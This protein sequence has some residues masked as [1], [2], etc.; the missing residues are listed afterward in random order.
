[1]SCRIQYTIRTTKLW[2]GLF[3][4]AIILFFHG[5]SDNLDSSGEGVRGYS[6]D[7]KTLF[8]SK[9]EPF[10]IAWVH[11]PKDLHPFSGLRGIEAVLLYSHFGWWDI[12]YETPFDDNNILVRSKEKFEND[13]LE[14]YQ[15][16]G[17]GK[18]FT[19]WIRQ[20]IRFHNGDEM[21][22]D[23][24][25]YSIK[26]MYLSRTASLFFGKRVP[27]L[28]VS[29]ESN[30]KFS[31]SSNT[32]HDWLWMLTIPIVNK[33]YEES[34][35]DN[36]E[37]V[38]MGAGPYNFVSF[39][40]SVLK[41]KHFT[42][43]WAGQQSVS[44]IEIHYFTDTAAAT[45]AFLDGR[46][47]YIFGLDNEDIHHIQKQH[48]VITFGVLENAAYQIILNTKMKPFDDIRVRKGLSL[49]IDRNEIL[50][51]NYG[52]AT[53]AVPA[54]VPLF[55][56]RPLT[57]PFAHAHNVKKAKKLFKMAGWEIQNKKLYRNGEQFKFTIFVANHNKKYTQVLRRIV[58]I[59]SEFGIECSI[60]YREFSEVW[61]LMST[62]EYDTVFSEL[63]DGRLLKENQRYYASDGY[64]NFTGIGDGYTDNLFMQAQKPDNEMMLIKEEIQRVLRQKV[65]SITLFYPVAYGAISKRYNL[66]DRIIKNPY[67]LYFLACCK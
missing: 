62:G 30:Y 27:N 16:S 47:D 31:V 26:K 13:A 20:K 52:F 48:D 8:D 21:T 66:Y 58:R 40:G 35:Y 37:Y 15:I 63:R 43:H 50:K 1:M 7:S 18:K 60:R 61:N 5:C 12:T 17:D 49:L 46:V 19:G 10:R 57:T 51:S 67:N 34:R 6:P 41:M 9:Q 24:V 14:K 36:G 38:P 65:P 44:D 33:K 42:N 39:N 25:A 55:R 3:G 64:L 53:I 59:F 2:R 23:D 28:T 32:D 45:M 4:F 56:T 54:D 29:M 11:E 22:A